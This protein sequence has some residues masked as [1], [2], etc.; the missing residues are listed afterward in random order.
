ML[1]LNFLLLRAIFALCTASSVQL[2]QTDNVN[3]LTPATDMRP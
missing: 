2:A 3:K 1:F